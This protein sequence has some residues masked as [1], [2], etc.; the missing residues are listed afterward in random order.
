MYEIKTVDVYEDFQKD[1]EMFDFSNYHA[2]SKHYDD[3]NK[4]VVYK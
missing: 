4:S 1:E 2:E 3:S